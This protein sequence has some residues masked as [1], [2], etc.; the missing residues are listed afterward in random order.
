[1]YKKNPIEVNNLEPNHTGRRFFLKHNNTEG[2]RLLP[3]NTNTHLAMNGMKVNK[4]K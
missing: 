1:M 3:Y 2:N 4:M